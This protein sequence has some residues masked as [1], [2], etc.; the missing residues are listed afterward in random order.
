M[1]TLICHSGIA[2]ER[3]RIEAV[4]RL[5]ST[6]VMPAVM[7]QDERAEQKR[8]AFND[9]LAGQGFWGALK[10]TPSSRFP[11]FD[12]FDG[13]ATEVRDM[14][15]DLVFEDD[16]ERV[17][18]YFGKLHFGIGLI[19]AAPGMGKSHLAAIIVI[20]LCLNPSIQKLYVS[21]ASNVTTDNILERITKIAEPL[22]AKL[23]SVG[24]PVKR[25]MLVRGYNSRMECDNCFKAL[26]D[27][28]L[29]EPGAWNSSPWR[30]ERSLCWWTL[31]ALGSSAV[32]PLTSDDSVE[33]WNLYHNLD[34]LLSPDQESSSLNRDMLTPLVRLARGLIT[35][36]DYLDGQT[37]DVRTKSLTSL[38][39]LVVS[40]ANVVATT[41]AA[42]SHD[43]YLTFNS[44]IARAVVFDEA[45][46]LFRAD[47]LLVFGNTPRPM[48]AVGDPKQLAPVLATAIERL[49]VGR[50]NRE[51]GVHNWPTNRFV[52][53][54][55]VSWL[56]W[57]IHLGFPVFHLH[58]QHR[59]A[60]GLFDMM[61]ETSYNDIRRFFKYSPLCRPIN[62]PLGVKVE[63]YV[64]V[65][66]H[67][68]S[69]S[70]EK[71]L[72]VFFNTRSCPCRNAPDSPSR[73]NPRQASCIAT[74]LDAMMK[75]L[76]IPPADV[77][78][79][80]P[81]RANQRVLQG[82]FQKEKVLQDVVCSTIDAFQGK[83]API[84]VVALCVTQEAL[85]SG[86]LFATDPR[87]LNVALTRHKSA[88]FVFGDINVVQ[89]SHFL[90]RYFSTLAEG[91]SSNDPT[92]GN[93]LRSITGSRRVVHLDGNPKVRSGK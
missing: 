68:T 81:Y 92:M 64:K 78:V 59:M 76:F 53:E 50:K 91:K 60:N 93:A 41:P 6:E 18:Q 56:S 3:K 11:H 1:V 30:F 63:Q 69:E 44:T 82:E 42:S 65:K 25:L 7:G 27:T 5:S 33:L 85:E 4:N 28:P 79:L 73:F 67:L 66:H 37:K 74:Y 8:L 90:Q 36:K 29:E 23:I 75:E 16:R 17:Q 58:T 48:I 24:H 87:R 80:T 54:A 72:P 51:P 55:D 10:A 22:V 32:P 35:A 47:G 46:T 19:S 13:V 88:L 49:N 34:A 31:R 39:A 26:M 52:D 77:V 15:I 2:N 71:L 57:F 45:G 12:V 38:M 83:E 43:P 21:A 62:F 86:P 20:L 84:V 61:V 9:L 70:P 40:C 89:G 14:C